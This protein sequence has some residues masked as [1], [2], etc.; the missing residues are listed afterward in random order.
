M[1]LVVGR[2][3]KVVATLPARLPSSSLSLPPSLSLGS[4]LASHRQNHLKI[5]S[6]MSQEDDSQAYRAA[7]TIHKLTVSSG[8]LQRARDGGESADKQGDELV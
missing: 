2:L 4:R 7:M 1:A 8:L 6:K 3:P 5:T